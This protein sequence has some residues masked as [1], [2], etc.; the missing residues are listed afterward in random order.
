MVVSEEYEKCIF[1]LCEEKTVNE[2]AVWLRC[3]EIGANVGVVNELSGWHEGVIKD[4]ELMDLVAVTVEHDTWIKGDEGAQRHVGEDDDWNMMVD[5]G[6]LKYWLRENI[7]NE[8]N[9]KWEKKYSFTKP[10]SC[11]SECDPER[12]RPS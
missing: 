1:L 11:E 2:F 12:E 9:P 7:K 5:F 6:N 3:V 4:V 10:E 8:E